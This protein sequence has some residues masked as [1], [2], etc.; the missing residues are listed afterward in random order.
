MNNL[1][2]IEPVYKEF[3]G[4]KQSVTE[5]ETYDDLPK[6]AKNYIEYLAEKLETPIKIISVGPK[7]KQIILK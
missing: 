3:L 7:R 6:E 1:D 5:A 2:Q 4:W